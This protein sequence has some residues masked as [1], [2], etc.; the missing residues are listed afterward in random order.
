MNIHENNKILANQ[1]NTKYRQNNW[2]LHQE[3]KYL[4]HSKTNKYNLPYVNR[5]KMK[6]SIISIYPMTIL[7]KIRHSFQIKPSGK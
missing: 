2:G 4:S 1:I 5:L 7:D 6:N 3:C